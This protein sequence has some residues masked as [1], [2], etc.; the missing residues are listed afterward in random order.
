MK[1]VVLVLV[2]VCG[3]VWGGL[4]ENRAQVKYLGGITFLLRDGCP[5]SSTVGE[6]E[7]YSSCVEHEKLHTQCSTD[8]L[9]SGDKLTV[10]VFSDL[11]TAVCFR[12][13][14]QQIHDCPVNGIR[15]DGGGSPGSEEVNQALADR[16]LG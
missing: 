14:I 15:L 5:P 4:L 13:N 8:T 16:F 9:Q 1:S 7:I 2:L 3:A 11:C 10:P 12:Q 6:R